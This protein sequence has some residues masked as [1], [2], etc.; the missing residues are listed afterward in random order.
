[1]ELL[2]SQR[3]VEFSAV[4]STKELWGGFALGVFLYLVGS[5]GGVWLIKQFGWQNSPWLG[6]VLAPVQ[7]MMVAPALLIMRRYGS[8][9]TLLGLNRFDWLMLLQTLFM[10]GLS[11]C[12]MITWGLILQPF[13]IQPQEPLVPLFGDGVDAF[14]SVFVVAAIL[15]PIVEEIVFRG[16]LF[17]GLRQRYHLG[18]AAVV[19]GA[20][21]GGI[22]LQPFAF[23]VLFLLGVLLALLYDRTGSL[24]APILMHFCINA[25]AVLAQYVAMSQGLI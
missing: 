2:Y 23:P 20:I 21:F 3:K 15:A 24:W 4:W 9:W 10:L 18:V 6:V 5:L 16:F 1:M 25:L 22:H 19:S 13:G 7:L 12:S 14:V 17:A 8:P 11:F